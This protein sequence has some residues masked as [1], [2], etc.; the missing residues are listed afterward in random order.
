MGIVWM[1]RGH[2]STGMF[3]AFSAAFG[4]FMGAMIYFSNG[5]ISLLHAV[6]DVAE[7]F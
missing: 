4:T 7:R 6:H 3:L 1:A 5:L 2:I